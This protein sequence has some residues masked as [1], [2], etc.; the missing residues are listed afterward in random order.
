MTIT[1]NSQADTDRALGLRAGDRVRLR[2]WNEIQATLD[3][4]GCT[5]KL[6]FMQE[7]VA[8]QGGTMT[9]DSRADKTCDTINLV[10]CTREMDDTVHL[11]NMRCDGSAHGG[12]QALCM[13]YFREQWLERVPDDQPFSPV[14]RDEAPPAEMVAT[15]DRFANVSPGYYRCQATQALDASRPLHG[16]G[17]YWTTLRTRNVPLRRVLMFVFWAIVNLYQ[18][19]SRHFVPRPLR[20]HGGVRLPDLRGEVVDGRWPEE[21]PL[22]LQPGELVEVRS[23]EEIRATLDDDQRNR[24]LWFDQEMVPL[25]G[26]RGRIVHRVQRLIDEKTGK[27]LRVKKDLYIVSGMLGCEGLHHKLCTRSVMGMMRDVW[28]RRVE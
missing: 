27:M 26:K 25:C 15:L 23:Q 24:G 16:L 10:G 19:F 20:F 6:P 8:L 2:P 13:F 11:T 18:K 17:H 14:P 12:C 4:D 3:A 5:D 22:D 1:Q 7:M 28:L 9:V 21:P